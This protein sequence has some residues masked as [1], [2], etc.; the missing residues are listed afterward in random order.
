MKKSTVDRIGRVIGAMIGSIV[1]TLVVGWIFDLSYA[2]K[3]L[4]LMIIFYGR[5]PTI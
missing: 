5:S 2:Q 1:V 4:C 3:G